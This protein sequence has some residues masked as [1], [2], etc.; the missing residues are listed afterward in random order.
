MV[1]Y[2]RFFAQP[3]LGNPSSQC[4]GGE[5]PLVGRPGLAL[6]QHLVDKPN[7]FHVT[8]TRRVRKLGRHYGEPW[9]DIDILTRH[10]AKHILWEHGFDLWGI[11]YLKRH[12]PATNVLQIIDLEWWHSDRHRVQ[13]PG[14]FPHTGLGT[15][16]DT[17][18]RLLYTCHRKH[19]AQDRQTW[20]SMVPRWVA[21]AP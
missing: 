2:E 11:T 3:G 15:V 7:A 1:P 8:M 18:V 6:L 16:L 19:L 12:C 4:L 13:H 17:Y 9:L 10:L 14:H 20:E 5:L 21:F